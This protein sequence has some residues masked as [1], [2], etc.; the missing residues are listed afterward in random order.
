MRPRAPLR[1]MRR[2]PH[3]VPRLPRP[4]GPPD[5]HLSVSIAANSDAVIATPLVRCT[6][7]RMPARFSFFFLP[8]HLCHT[9]VPNCLCI[10][11]LFRFDFDSSDVPSHFAFDVDAKSAFSQ[12]VPQLFLTTSSVATRWESL[13]NG[14]PHHQNATRD[15][16]PHLPTPPQ[17]LYIS[18]LPCSSIAIGCQLAIGEP[19]PKSLPPFVCPNMMF[20]Q[21]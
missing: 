3:A 7:K 18:S 21:F 20:Q 19:I 8:F 15:H 2:G 6:C 12:S 9:T 17:R 10:C 11:P 1:G 16:Y 5:P 14:L 4:R 13:S